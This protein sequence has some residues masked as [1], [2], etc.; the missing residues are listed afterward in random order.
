MLTKV[1]IVSP[2]KHFKSNNLPKFVL[3]TKKANEQTETH[4]KTLD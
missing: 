1:L 3:L 4:N 2:R